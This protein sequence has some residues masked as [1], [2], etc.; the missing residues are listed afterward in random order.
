MYPLRLIKFIINILS[1]PFLFLYRTIWWKI[2]NQDNFT[3][4]ERHTICI[5]SIHV[6]RMTYGKIKV[7]NDLPDRTLSIGSFCSIADNVTFL[8]GLEHDLHH[9]MTYPFKQNLGLESIG[10]RDAGSKG[11]IEIGD[12]VWIGYGAIIL[13]GVTVGQGAVIAAGAVVTKDIPAYGIVGGVPARIIGYRFQKET[14]DK[15]L[16][17]DLSKLTNEQIYSHI[18]DLYKD[19]EDIED[20]ADFSWMKDKCYPSSIIEDK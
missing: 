6:G 16:L 13:S 3:S 19:P 9:V 8:L 5:H 2:N 7:Y 15:L 17:K 10:F 1:N 18:N 14:R 12:D 11:N 4:L 20:P